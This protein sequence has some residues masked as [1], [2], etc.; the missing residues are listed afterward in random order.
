M[1]EP[2]LG[3]IGVAQLVLEVAQQPLIFFFFF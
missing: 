2:T 3:Q 1:A